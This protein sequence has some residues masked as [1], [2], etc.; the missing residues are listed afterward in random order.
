M[1]NIEMGVQLRQCSVMLTAHT[2]DDAENLCDKI[3]ILIKGQIYSLSSPQELRIRSGDGYDIQ[4]KEYKNKHEIAQF[5][6]KKFQIS[7][8]SNGRIKKNYNSMQTII[9]FQFFGTWLVFRFL[10]CLFLTA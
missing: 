10:Q 4:L 2:M 5:L 6:K 7:L 3:A 1:E 8:K 9:D